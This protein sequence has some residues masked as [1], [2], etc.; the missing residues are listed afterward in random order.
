MIEQ[1]LKC[2]FCLC[3]G[4]AKAQRYFFGT[5]AIWAILSFGLRA[6][7][8]SLGYTAEMW[9]KHS[10]DLA[11]LINSLGQSLVQCQLLKWVIRRRV[12]PSND[13]V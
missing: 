9:A 3:T 8:Q 12:Q 13:V 11:V 5:V 2:V 7:L 4:L 1:V 10:L 6:A